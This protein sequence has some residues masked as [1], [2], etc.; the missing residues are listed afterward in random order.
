VDNS[1]HI[2]KVYNPGSNLS[3]AEEMTV[4]RSVSV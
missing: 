3:V 4:K 1:K 2:K